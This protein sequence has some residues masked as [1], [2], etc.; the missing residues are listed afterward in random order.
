MQ[1]STKSLKNRIFRFSWNYIAA[2]ALRAYL[3]KIIKTMLNISAMAHTFRVYSIA[4]VVWVHKVWAKVAWVHETLAWVQK[5]GVCQKI[6]VV[7]RNGVGFQ[8]FAI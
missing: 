2:K 3:R 8:C 5:N 7:Q 6:D 4:W 1:K